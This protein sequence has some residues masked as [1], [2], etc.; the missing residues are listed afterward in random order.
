MFSPSHRRLVPLFAILF[1][2]SSGVIEAK[3]ARVDIENVPIERVLQ[4]LER[5]AQQSPR[6]VG[7]RLNLGRVH[8]MAYASKSETAPVRKSRSP[9]DPQSNEPEFGVIT[10]EFGNVQVKETTDANVLS[11]ARQHLAKAI[12]NYAA[13]IA[14]E[15]SNLVARLGRA[16]CLEQAGDKRGA[17][18]GYRDLLK[19][20]RGSESARR[21]PGLQNYMPMTVEVAGYLI[22]LLDS[23]K[24]AVEIAQI[25][26]R[27]ANVERIMST[28]PIT[29]IAIPLND[30][31]QASDLVRPAL[32]V[33]F[34]ADGSGLLKRWT[35]ISP[36]AGW[37]VFDKS[38]RK[39][40]SSSLDLFGNVTFWLFWENG[41]QALQTLDDDG[42]GQLQGQELTG[43]AIWRDENANGVADIGEVKPLAEW[44]I[45][46]LSCS[47]E[48]RE[49]DPNS[50][51][52]S[53]SGVTFGNGSV[54]PTFDLLLYPR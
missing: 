2:I 6:D 52:W 4:N 5:R 45:T 42:D 34:D 8:A 7:T 11:Q 48:W 20:L 47:F 15:P 30:G 38:G 50:I 19:D 16:W 22:P 36:K 54:R 49:D 31:L 53:A 18:T 33:A 28:R 14:I 32:S 23:T 25:R 41:Y 1:F 12:E 43:L 37:L 24:D 27:V 21:L 46:R 9:S 29:P 44:H 51:A 39:Q 13:A 3:F 17:I 26:A 35:W 10:S 40:V